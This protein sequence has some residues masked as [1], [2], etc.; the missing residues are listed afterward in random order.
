[1]SG[2]T[3]GQTGKALKRK[4]SGTSLKAEKPGQGETSLE[5]KGSKP[6]AHDRL[7]PSHSGELFVVAT[8]IGNMGDITLRAIETL[9][10]ADGVICEDSR[11]SGGLLHRLGLKKPLIP[12]H[13]HNAEKA[14]PGILE[15][16]AGGERLALVSDAGTPLV[17]DP[18]CKLVQAAHAQGIKV[19][20]LPGPSALLTALVLSGQPSDRFLFAGFLPAKQGQRKKVIAELK[21]IQATLILYEAPHRLA[22][23]LADLAEGLGDR[24]TSVCR[25]LTKLYEEVL[26]RNLRE[27]ASHYNQAGPPKGEIVIVIAPPEETSSDLN[28]IENLL[29]TA[30]ET[31]S[32]R[33]AA[34]TVAKASGRPRREIY[35]Q[36]LALSAKSRNP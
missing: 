22:E 28:D 8:P 9:K 1:M 24:S 30:L 29:R 6:P 10:Q 20:A 33:D 32:V 11:V 5:I 25:E 3:P 15:R 27:L 21:D 36:A 2:Q 19:S 14:R 23:S 16:L 35:N 13:D 4:T 26:R 7:I 18:G 34:E 31:L 12:Y 17:S